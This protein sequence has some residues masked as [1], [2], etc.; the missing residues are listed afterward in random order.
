MF[1]ALALTAGPFV[2]SAMFGGA[3]NFNQDMQG[4]D[5]LLK[6]IEPGGLLSI[7]SQVIGVV[8]VLFSLYQM[9]RPE[10]QVYEAEKVCYESVRSLV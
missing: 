3:S 5:D 4:F 6:W 8:F 9:V 2:M 10:T 1:A 7:A